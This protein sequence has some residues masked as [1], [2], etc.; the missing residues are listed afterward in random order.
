MLFF[1]GRF[2]EAGA[3]IEDLDAAEAAWVDHDEDDRNS[4]RDALGECLESL[5]ERSRRALDLFYREGAGRSLIA[6]VLGLT[7]DGVKTL[8]RRARE[9]LRACI[10]RRLG[11]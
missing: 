1:V 6:D 9:A 10:R 2:G 5:T 7:V 4:D 3:A 8:M 11:T